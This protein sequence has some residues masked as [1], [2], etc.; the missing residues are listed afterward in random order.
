M[1]PEFPKEPSVLLEHDKTGKPTHVVAGHSV[2]HP[3]PAVVLT[4]YD[5][6]AL[7]SGDL[8]RA[9]QLAS[10]IYKLTPVTA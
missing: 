2:G 3:S 8:R 6:E 5:M 1:D 10:G 7:R 4:A 9:S